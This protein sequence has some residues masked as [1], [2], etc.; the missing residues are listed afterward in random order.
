MELNLDALVKASLETQIIKAFKEAPEAIDALVSACLS[1]PVNEY[2]T[3]PSGYGDK[4]MPY[5]SWLAQETI[6][7]IARTAVREHIK[8]MEPVIRE[9]VIAALTGEQVVDAFTKNILSATEDEWKIKVIIHPE[10]E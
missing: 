2:G 9:K 10:K 5:L 6:Q 7:N 4:K 8:T 1:M 3:K